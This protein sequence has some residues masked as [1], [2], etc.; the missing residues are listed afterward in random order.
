VV[1]A[2]SSK[3]SPYQ[4]KKKKKEEETEKKEMRAPLAPTLCLSELCILGV[5][6]GGYVPFSLL[7]TKSLGFKKQGR[8]KK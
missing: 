8:E 7:L 5:W 4:K 3:P 6:E 1:E 2:L